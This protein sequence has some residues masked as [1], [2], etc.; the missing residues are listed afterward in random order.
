MGKRLSK[1]QLSRYDRE[2]VVFPIP[3]LTAAEADTYRAAFEELEDLA[4]GNLKR[5]GGAHLF[6]RW[7][8]E[9]AT[10]PAVLDA[11]SDMLG[12]KLL[13]AGTLIFC[14]YPHDPAYVS[15]HQDSL[16]SN[17]HLMPTTSAWIA[18]SDSTAANGCMRVIPG[19]HL[20]GLVAHRLAPTTMNLLDKG[21][22]VESDVDEAR[23]TDLVLRAGEMS[24]H[25][26][27]LIHGSSPNRSDVK[28]LGF[29]VRYITD[30]FRKSAQPVLRA[31]GSSDCSHLNLTKAPPDVSIPEAFTAWKKSESETSSRQIEVSAAR[32]QP[33]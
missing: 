3:V 11:V 32:D 31:R 26:G 7:A 5:V 25:H 16:Y 18:L 23:A 20:H 4:G 2:G 14:K 33:H 13:I 12:D 28:R 21:Q 8:Y 27:N 1:Q 9:L 15:W 29:I 6:F 30:Q 19:S 10:H 22:E 17:W 24:L